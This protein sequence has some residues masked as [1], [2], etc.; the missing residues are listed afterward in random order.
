MKQSRVEA[1]PCW[2]QG[3]CVQTVL[4]VNVHP[5]VPSRCD[6][7]LCRKVDSHST[8]IATASQAT[9]TALG[10][11]TES[12]LCTDI[13]KHDATIEIPLLSTLKFS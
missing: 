9:R 11:R 2:P 10:L 8:D 13:R 7:E 5:E 6:R 12:T 3:T 4:R 1:R